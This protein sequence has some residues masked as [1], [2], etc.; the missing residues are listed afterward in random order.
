MRYVALG[1]STGVGV[2]AH[3][4]RGY[5]AYVREALAAAGIEVELNILARSG[6]TTRDVVREQLPRLRGEQPALITLGIATN[7][8][9]RLVPLAEIEANLEIIA[10]HLRPPTLVCNVI[11]LSLAPVRAMVERVMHVP[12]SAFHARL[13]H[14]NAAIASTCERHGFGLV[15]LFSYSQRELPLHPEYFSADGFHPSAAGYQ[16]WGTLLGEAAVAVCTPRR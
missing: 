16:A 2:G 9:W 7:D 12:M 13:A 14:I 11:D 6:A 8:L 10:T 1:D 4:A 15:D 3:D 5:P